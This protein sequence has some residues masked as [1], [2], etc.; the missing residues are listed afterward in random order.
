MSILRGG[1]PFDDLWARRTTIE[2]DGVEIDML[3]IE[4]LIRAKKT[5]Q[6]KDWPM[7]RRLVERTWIAGQGS[8]QFWLT[9]LR[10]A[11]LLLDAVTRYRD[12]ALVIAAR[13][14]ALAAAL[15]GEIAEI[16]RCLE[17]EERRERQLDRE[18]WKPLRA[19]ME[20]SD[21]N[22]GL[23]RLMNTLQAPDPNRVAKP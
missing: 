12:D 1:A 5:Q 8:P 13:R 18:Y 6:D 10:S 4:D 7:V 2:S 21:T 14:P 20:D 9:K 17:E 19:E 23:L 3:S 16:A 15:L 22:G 11:D